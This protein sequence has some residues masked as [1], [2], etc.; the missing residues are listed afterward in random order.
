MNPKA[1]SMAT[2]GRNSSNIRHNVEMA[3]DTKHN[4][5]I[6]HEVVNEGTD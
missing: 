2:S 6:A 4:L 1:R 5:T 3:V